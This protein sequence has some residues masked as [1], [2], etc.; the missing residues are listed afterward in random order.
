MSSSSSADDSPSPEY[1]SGEFASSDWAPPISHHSSSGGATGSARGHLGARDEEGLQRSIDYTQAPCQDENSISIE[2]DDDEPDESG[3]LPEVIGGYRVGTRLGRGGMGEVFQAEHRSMGRTVALK[4]LPAKLLGRSGSI[5]RFHE[6]IR[7]ASRLMHPNIVTA[8]D[9]GQSEGIHFLA[10]E[11]V[12][13]KTLS[14]IVAEEGPLSIGDATSAV[15][16]AAFAL[17]HAHAAGIIHRDVKPGN[18]MRSKEGTIKLLDLGLARFARNWHNANE[19][20]LGNS[21]IGIID[22]KQLASPPPQPHNNGSPGSPQTHESLHPLS[23][24]RRSLLGT[25]AFISPEQL[26]DPESADARSD[27]YSL[28]ATLFYLLVGHPPFPG[29]MI[30]Q[31]YG[32]RHGEIPDLMT[33]RQDVD[34]TLAN[35]VNR[36]LAKS[37]AQRY[38]SMDEVAR[39]MSPYDNDRSTPAWVLDFAERKVDEERSTANEVSRS[40]R[41]TRNKILSVLGIDMG[42][43]HAATAVGL[44]DGNIQNGWPSLT[45]GRPQPLFRMAVAERPATSNTPGGE[46][47]FGQAAYELRKDYPHLVSH[48]QTMYFGRHEMLRRVA[49]RMCPP[50]VA[51][52]LCLRRLVGN[53]LM[54]HCT[55]Q[56]STPPPVPGS[57]DSGSSDGSIDSVLGATWQRHES[58][59]DAVAITVPGCYDQ[60]HRRSVYTAARIAGLPSVRLIDRGVAIAQFALRSDQGDAEKQS[61]QPPRTSAD[62]GPETILYVGLTG[63]ALDVSVIRRRGRKIEQIAS[64]GH[65]QQNATTWSSRLVEMIQSRLVHRPRRRS[66]PNANRSWLLHAA[67]VQIAGER[68]MN[69]LLLLPETSVEIQHDGKTETVQLSRAKWLESCEVLMTSIEQC[70]ALA[71]SRAEISAENI[72]RCFVLSPILRLPPIRQ[73]VFASLGKNTSIEFFDYPDAAIGAAA[74]LMSELPGHRSGVLPAQCSASHSVGFVVSEATGKR[75][76]LPI[77]TRGTPTPSRTNRQLGG[78]AKDEAL[79]LALVESSGLQDEAWHTLGRHRIA[80]DASE[81]SPTRKIGFEVDINGL[82]SVHLERPDLGRTVRLP[83]L[84]ELDVS[85][86]QWEDWREW[87]EDQA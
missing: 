84:P 10:M 23:S 61:D 15:R 41:A 25:L 66:N 73:R 16:Q 78:T 9:A 50:L 52:A 27:Q 76:I 80:V 12:D 59:P 68:A 67:K 11:F 29:E 7:A 53:T 83:S 3:P 5:E 44:P 72:S 71:C 64:A 33:Y 62:E 14:Q 37:P 36:M 30:D 77:I 24:P 51:A 81:Q 31:I 1:D 79:T 32:H 69:S 42:L 54:N 21:K 8:F 40:T 17:H 38:A 22:P 57:H 48:C 6:E 82:L 20:K 26:E 47:L 63:Q 86:D 34:L 58:W 74:C 18:L 43:T 4:I 60:L 56:K 65:W 85:L 87:V 35:I 49:G 75:K 19:S 46:V 45:S 39:A 28:G 2:L 70:I 13:G 55:A